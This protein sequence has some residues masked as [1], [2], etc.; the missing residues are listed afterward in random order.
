MIS[1]NAAEKAAI[2][3]A[4]EE[5]SQ[6]ID[7]MKQIRLVTNCFMITFEQLKQEKRA[8]YNESRVSQILAVIKIFMKCKR[9]QELYDELQT[10]LPALFGYTNAGVLFYDENGG[11][12]YSIRCNDYKKTVIT[13]EHMMHFPLKMGITGIAIDE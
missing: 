11:N 1:S 8:N 13:D 9:H 6:S 2:L 12:L 5:L 4:Q 3:A 10:H 7:Y